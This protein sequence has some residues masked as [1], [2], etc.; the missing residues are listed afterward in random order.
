MGGTALFIGFGRRSGMDGRGRA[1]ISIASSL[2]AVAVLVGGCGPSAVPIGRTESVTVHIDTCGEVYTHVHGRVWR[3]RDLA[4]QAWG[5]SGLER[6]SIRYLPQGEA[7]FTGADGSLVRLWQ[8]TDS[9][10]QCR[11]P[12][13]PT[14]DT[15]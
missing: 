1:A 10:F 7:R 15:Q 3:A 4:P 8:T 14:G 5:Q 2:V 6:G 9:N 13:I 12:A 11:G